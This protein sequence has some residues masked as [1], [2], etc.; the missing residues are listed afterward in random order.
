[1]GVDKNKLK[2]QKQALTAW[3]GQNGFGTLEI[4]TGVGK[5]FISI[6]GA[7]YI[8]RELSPSKPKVLFLAETTSREYDF[9]KDVEKYN[10]LFDTDFLNDFD[11]QFMCYQ[12]A[13]KLSEEHYD[14]V[15]ADEIHMGL[16]LEYSK[17]FENN[18]YTYIMGLTATT[19]RKV[20][21]ESLDESNKI[22]EL[23]KGELLDKYAP[24][25]FTYDLNISREDNNS[26][27]LDVFVIYHKMDSV[28]KTMIGGTKKK[29]FKTTEKA[30]YEYWNKQVAKCYYMPNGKQK[31]FAIQNAVRKRSKVLYDLPSKSVEVKKLVKILDNKTLIVGNSLDSL[32]EITD[33]T[34]SS[35]NTPKK[36]EKLRKDFDEGK[37]NLIAGWK[38]VEQ[39]ANLEDLDNLIMMSYYS[40]QLPLIQRI[41]R[42]RNKKG[43]GKVFIFVTK[44]SKEEEWFE[45][46]FEGIDVYN[47]IKVEGVDDYI[48]NYT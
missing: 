47:I 17:F 41:G 32:Y 7:Y 21:Y 8:K 40:K 19:D 20:K 9:L 35:R 48:K 42:L 14:Y 38:K 3:W 44:D 13:Y 6:M 37:I 4:A 25:V 10:K 28:N 27:E 24:V 2:I 11:Y 36:N 43:T 31:D 5:T 46:M 18:A 22:V 34:I 45:K 30:N 23:T 39:G 12:S 29:P 15:I 26:R 16:T 33:N 1:M